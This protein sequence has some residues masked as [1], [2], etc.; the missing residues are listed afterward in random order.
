[1]KTLHEVLK[2][3]ELREVAVGHFNFSELVVLKA[4]VAAARDLDVPVLLGVSESEREFVGVRQAVA[5][6]K[7]MRDEYDHP[8]FL[9]AD[10]THSLAKAEE[11]AKAGFDEILF[12]GSSLPLEENVQQTKKAVEAIKS[13][14]ASILVEGEVGYVGTSS[15]ILEKVPEGANVLTTPEE[16]KQFVEATGIDA[17]APAV[18]NMHGLLQTMVRGEAEK[19]LHIERIADIKRTTGVFLT[20]HGGSGTNDDDL[21]KAI[22]A[23]ITIIH[24]N[25]EIRLAWRRGIEASL[26]L[27]PQAVSPYKILPGAFQAVKDV[28]NARLQLFSSK[29][30]GT[31]SQAA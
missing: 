21:K 20:L 29:L 10:H 2:D 30:P 24:I 13:I 15:E 4:I 26:A 17:L 23:G 31:K 1:M 25:T 19:R 12:D 16:A 22:K 5:L 8:V 11:A 6:I 18:G 9:N 14:D 27:K 7:S 28:V 3:A